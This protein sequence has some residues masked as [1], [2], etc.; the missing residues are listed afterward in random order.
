M[1]T[2]RNAAPFALAHW[3]WE[4]AGRLARGERP[5]G[6]TRPDRRMKTAAKFQQAMAACK[7]PR[8]LEAVR[9]KSPDLC[10][11]YDIYLDDG[12]LRA[13]LEAFVLA[14]LADAQVA[15]KCGLP[16]EVVAVYADLFLDVREHL[17]AVDWLYGKLVG[18]GIWQG[19]RDGELRAFWA[20]C[21]LA[22]GPFSL[23]F[24]VNAYI[25]LMQPKERPSLRVY[26]QED[27]GVPLGLQALVAV[28]ML[29]CQEVTSIVGAVQRQL[30]T[31]KAQGSR[32][33]KER[34][35]A[36]AR[37][38]IIKYVRTKPLAT[39]AT[40]VKSTRPRR[41]KTSHKPSR[42]PKSKVTWDATAGRILAQLGA[43]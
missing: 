25:R 19:F 9:R 6:C 20:W 37:A 11:A 43:R 26:L 41:R 5:V 33:A 27:E 22:G 34:A 36:A 1:T 28:K 23:E 18:A 38:V 31:A 10:L 21:A 30:A 24:L 8:E 40:T 3:R 39:M 17:K 14:G 4:D 29:P 16:V 7:S 13:Q 2:S 15:A 32:E 12:V 42:L 35:L